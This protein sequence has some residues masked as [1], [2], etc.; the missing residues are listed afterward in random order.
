MEQPFYFGTV[1]SRRVF[2][3]RSKELDRLHQNMSNGVNTILI[4]PRR[5]GKTSLVKKATET[6]KD[7]EIRFVFLDLF[8]IAS[9]KQFLE[10]YSV[11]VLEATQSDAQELLRNLR[12]FFSKLI[13]ELSF[14]S[15]PQP[16]VSFSL[17]WKDEQWPEEEILDLP[18]KIASE[19]NI[20]LILCLDEFQ[21]IASFDKEHSFQKL[22][23]SHWQHHT[24]VSYILYGSKRSLMNEFFTSQ[25]MP[26]YGFGDLLYLEKIVASEW[27]EYIMRRFQL[28]G[29]E[30]DPDTAL[31]IS[32]LMECHSY[33][34][35]QL[36]YVT[37]LNTK[38]KA[39]NLDLELALEVMLQQNQILYRKM[40]DEL[41]SPQIE[42]LRALSEGVSQ[43]YKKKNMKKYDL[44]S[45][46]NIKRIREALE[47][48][49]ILDFFEGKP[50]FLDPAFALW[51]KKY[52]LRWNI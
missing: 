25:S 49:E 14:S 51:F 12:K 23:R 52:Y 27:Q 28:F 19:Q 45:V 47:A 4:S 9:R 50:Q 41:S 11:Q 42:Y 3:N 2:L 10:H 17:H 13:P 16:E 35:Q 48:K 7:Q 20:R 37:F 38:Q 8:R 24:D 40:V 46:G 15:D 29:K 6:F 44:G 32:Q 21:N 5:W 22:L 1:V 26:F 33:Y 18:Q 34:V 39:A 36:A 30:I 31:R 43:F